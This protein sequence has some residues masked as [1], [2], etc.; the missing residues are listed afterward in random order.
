[1]IA[2]DKSNRYAFYRGKDWIGPK[3]KETVEQT[4]E[5][6]YA[7]DFDEQYRGN[8]YKQQNMMLE[9]NRA[10]LDYLYDQDIEG[11]MVQEAK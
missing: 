6:G 3:E 10:N 9:E 11:V 2:R 5:Y 4:E 7:Q 8:L 1:V